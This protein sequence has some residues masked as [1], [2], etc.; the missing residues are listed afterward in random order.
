M[1]T[2]TKVNFRTR[3]DKNLKKT[4]KI[5]NPLISSLMIEISQRLNKDFPLLERYCLWTTDWF[6]EFMKHQV[7]HN[8]LIIEVE[9]DAMEFLFYYLKN[10]NYKEVFLITNKKEEKILERYINQAEQPIIIKKLI[11]KAPIHKK[12][13]I[14]IPTLE[15]IIVDLFCQENL[16]ATY[17]SEEKRIFEQVINNYEFDLKKYYSYAKRRNKLEEV[18]KYIL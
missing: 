15:K 11:T 3:F 12:N 2:T 5:F 18:K 8:L 6:N 16:L 10:N 13:D 7:I 1:Q 9:N 4:K 14:Y 17:V